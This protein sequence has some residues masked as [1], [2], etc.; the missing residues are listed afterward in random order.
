MYIYIYS[1]VVI[2]IHIQE[3]ITHGGAKKELLHHLTQWDLAW[4]RVTK[5]VD[6]GLQGVSDR[7]NVFKPVQLTAEQKIHRMCD[8]ED[9]VT[10]GSDSESESVQSSCSTEALPSTGPP[11]KRRVT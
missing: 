6:L 7:V 9:A 11:K 10:L 5:V 1:C 2:S 4:P 8:M 3:R